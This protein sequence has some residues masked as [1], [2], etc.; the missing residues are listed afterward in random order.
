MQ[1]T[2]EKTELSLNQKYC[3][4]L[5]CNVFV[6]CGE[7]G[8]V[9]LSAHLCDGGN[10]KKCDHYKGVGFRKDEPLLYK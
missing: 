5:S 9:C 4:N 8:S 6:L 7:D 1:N 2:D 3:G 10:G